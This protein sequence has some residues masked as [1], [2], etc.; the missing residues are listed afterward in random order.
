MTKKPPRRVARVVV[1]VAEIAEEEARIVGAEC[2]RADA[3]GGKRVEVLVKDC[4]ARAP[5]PA[6][7][8]FLLRDARAVADH[9]LRF[10]DAVVLPDRAA[11]ASLPFFADGILQR[12][13]GGVGAAER[14]EIVAVLDAG[15][16][17][18]APV[19]RRDRM[20]QRDAVARDGLK[21]ALRR[22]A[23]FHDRACGAVAKREQH[24]VAERADEAPFAG[25][26]D[27]VALLRRHAG[28]VAVAQA[29]RASG[30]RGRRPSA[31]RWCPR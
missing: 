28:A 8:A 19:E 27:D 2:Q 6:G 20:E 11:E 23:V 25:G 31:C 12:L 7:G 3:A 14:G 17:Q 26:E 15:R 1:L 30:G 13:A 29:L 9:H 18:D 4:G 10:G 5:G 22:G 24:V 16:R 21:D